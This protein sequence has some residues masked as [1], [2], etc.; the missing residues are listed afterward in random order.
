MRIS[1]ISRGAAIEPFSPGRLIEPFSPGAPARGSGSVRWWVRADAGWCWWGS[2]G[3]PR[4]GRVQI[5][6]KGVSRRDRPREEARNIN[7]FVADLDK[8][9]RRGPRGRVAAD[10][11]TFLRR[12][13]SGRVGLFPTRA[14]VLHI[15]EGRPRGQIPDFPRDY[16]VIPRTSVSSERA[17]MCRTN[18]SAH[19]RISTVLNAGT[20]PHDSA[21]PPPVGSS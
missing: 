14:V 17:P 4:R 7:A 19:G 9:R 2:W 11:V 10:R 21:D 8:P 15:G 5:C 1:T 18:L 16:G 3:G 13:T 20:F 12:V 6:H